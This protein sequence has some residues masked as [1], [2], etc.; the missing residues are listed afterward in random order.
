MGQSKSV[1]ILFPSVSAIARDVDNNQFASVQIQCYTAIEFCADANDWIRFALSCIQ[2]SQ[3]YPTEATKSLKHAFFAY[4]LAAMVCNLNDEF[5]T[6]KTY[7]TMAKTVLGKPS[8][9]DSFFQ[10]MG[11]PLEAEIVSQPALLGPINM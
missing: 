3:T 5:E 11:F 6:S 2:E 8:Y 9:A 10:E 4:M 7:R 1:D